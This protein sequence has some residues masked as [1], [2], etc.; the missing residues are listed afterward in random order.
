[1]TPSGIEPATFRFVA[2][3]LNH[4]ATAVPTCV[5]V[6]VCVC[7]YVYIYI[8]QNLVSQVFV[9][10]SSLVNASHREIHT[11]QLRILRCIK[12]LEFPGISPSAAEVCA[13]VRTCGGP[14]DD[15]A[16][17]HQAAHFRKSQ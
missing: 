6:C 11:A 3:Y 2:Q 16:G 10:C 17:V 5:C 7:V 9:M 15:G 12:K 14:L 4:C 8:Y 1:M 13:C